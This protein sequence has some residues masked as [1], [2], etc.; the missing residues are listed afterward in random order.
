MTTYL[1]TGGAGF[2]SSHLAEALVE[3]G[4][5]VVCFDNLSTGR[6]DNLS[7]IV[8]HS[9]AEFVHGS[10]LDEAAVDA[11]VHRCDVVVHLA[12]AVGVRLIIDE[13]LRSFLTNLHGSQ[14]VIEAALR[15]RRKILIASTSE[16]YGRN[17]SLPLSEESD[18]QLGPPD[19]ARWSYAAAKYVDE[20][21][22]YSYHRERNLDA[23]VV[24]FFNTVG[25]RQTGEYG[26]VV[27]RLVRQALAGTSLTV[28][29]TGEQTR[30]FCHVSDVVE[31]LLLMLDDDGCIGQVFNIGSSD[32]V[33]ILDLATRIVERTKSPSSI[34]LVPYHEAFAAGFEDIARRVPDTTKFRSRTGWSVRRSLDDIIDDIVAHERSGGG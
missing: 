28:H 7:H 5:Q 32:E 13:P 4:D 15:Y 18:S 30:C 29:G 27:P 23:L 16:I 3:R 14:I 26:M 6:L 17:A 11:L 33:S 12:A 9:R 2:I 22:A 34:S 20:V 21:L 19:I 25:P 10:I 31:A 8:G 24:R 1:L